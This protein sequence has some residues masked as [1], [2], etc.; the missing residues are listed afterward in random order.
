MS[1][2]LS[3][4]HFTMQSPVGLIRFFFMKLYFQ[5]WL[6]KINWVDHVKQ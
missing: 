4:I 6:Y 3:L 2:L 1:Q 5:S